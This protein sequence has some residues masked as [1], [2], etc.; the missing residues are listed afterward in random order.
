MQ[1]ILHH[2]GQRDVKQAVL[3]AGIDWQQH[4]TPERGQKSTTDQLCASDIFASAGAQHFGC[5]IR[6]MGLHNRVVH[7]VSQR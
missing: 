4:P 3:V 5:L 1:R 2:P 7:G 6:V